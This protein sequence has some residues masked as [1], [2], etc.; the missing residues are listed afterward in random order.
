MIIPEPSPEFLTVDKES[1]TS[2]KET[3]AATTAD[4]NTALVQNAGS[5]TITDRTFTKSG[6]DTITTTAGNSRGLDA[7]YGGTIITNSVY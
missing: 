7:T 1:T 5:L 3:Y 4:Q 6:E 2:D